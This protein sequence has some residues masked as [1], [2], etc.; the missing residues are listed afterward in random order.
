M[1][2]GKWILQDEDANV[3][4][5]QECGFETQLTDGD[6]NDNNYNFCPRCGFRVIPRLEG[7]EY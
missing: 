1:N 5:C 3:W 7:S 4:S 6:P 2:N